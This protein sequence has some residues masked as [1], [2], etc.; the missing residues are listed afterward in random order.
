MKRQVLLGITLT[1]LLGL[2]LLF[3]PMA[4]AD[5]ETKAKPVFKPMVSGAPTRRVGGGSR[6]SEGGS[7]HLTVL[8]PESTGYT[9]DPQPALYWSVSEKTDKPVKL[10]LVYADIALGTK[11]LLETMIS[12]ANQGIQGLDLGD[13]QV[14][15]KPD[16]EYEWSVS[17]EVDPKQPSSN[18]VSGGTLMLKTDG[19]PATLSQQ[20]KTATEQE[21]TFLFAEAGLWYDA[22]GTL[23]QLIDKQPQDKSLREQRA[24]LLEQVKL[25]Q[26][27]KQDLVF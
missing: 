15:L 4:Q 18:L 6:G 22:I 13:H 14:T 5:E 24:S 1:T 21:K 16:V 26:V 12:P 7:I 10:T 19:F 11:P 20:L 25:E 8:A 3:N 17:I 27:A 2:P 9:L 23:S